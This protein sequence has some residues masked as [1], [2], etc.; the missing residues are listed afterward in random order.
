MTDGLSGTVQFSR[1]IEDGSEEDLQVSYVPVIGRTLRVLQTND[2]AKGAKQEEMQMFSLAVVRLQ[3]EIERPFTVSKVASDHELKSIS[4]MVILV[5]V[6]IALLSAILTVMISLAV[7]RPMLCLLQMVRAINQGHLDE[8]ISPLEGG[9]REVTQVYNSFASLF[10]IVRVSNTAFYSGD[11]DWACHIVHDAINLFKKLGDEKAIAIGCNN[12]GN[13]LSSLLSAGKLSSRRP[14]AFSGQEALSI[15]KAAEYYDVAIRIGHK[16]LDEATSDS[17]K[18]KYAEQLADRYMNRAMYCLEMMNHENGRRE[19]KESQSCADR[20]EFFQQLGY[21]DLMRAQDL[22]VK[23]RNYWLENKLLLANSEQY[24]NR[25]LRRLYAAAV[26][27]KM[28]KTDGIL[29]AFDIDGLMQEANQFLTACWEEEHAPLFDK[30]SRIGRLQ[31]LE[32]AVISLLT[33]YG[34]GNEVRAAQYAIRML[35]EDEF[36]IDSA[37]VASADAILRF[38]SSQSSERKKTEIEGNV[39][40]HESF[41]GPWSKL[42]ESETREDI[43]QMLRR[44]KTSLDQPKAVIF[45]MD[46]QNQYPNMPQEK[47]AGN[48]K[49]STSKHTDSG[50]SSSSAASSDRA[51]FL[52]QFCSALYDLICHEEDLVGVAVPSSSQYPV[53]MSR[54]FENGEIQV[55]EIQSLTKREPVA[56]S[57]NSGNCTP[58]SALYWTLRTICN[59]DFPTGT[60]CFVFVID[61]RGG[62]VPTETAASRLQRSKGISETLQTNT[63]VHGNSNS[64]EKTDLES[65]ISKINDEHDWCLHVVVIGYELSDNDKRIEYYC[66][67]TSA[68]DLSTYIQ[69][70]RRWGSESALDHVISLLASRNGPVRDNNVQRGLTMQR[71]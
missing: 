27:V 66:N 60:D 39:E 1:T 61:D 4:S 22:D 48:F 53:E 36:L 24:F 30:I 23:A 2:Y 59:A 10:K 16:E 18:A 38:L 62:P 67:L 65:L 12:L 28:D 41:Q 43:N 64:P 3:E 33:S 44:C 63:S 56:G 54:K 52:G 31:Q 32:G 68:T 50:W 70:D 19:E 5:D 71:F 13:I 34:N 55:Q 51:D 29:E 15:D 37:F 25:I 47:A 26:V 58:C 57:A 45:A 11:I 17:L 42:A 49:S 69:L 14:L 21:D 20:G 7:T 40:R 6:F 46:L 35:V 9:S 8:G